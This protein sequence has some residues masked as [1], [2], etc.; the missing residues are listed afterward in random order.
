MITL[1]FIGIHTGNFK[2][3]F[4]LTKN[5]VPPKEINMIGIYKL[6]NKI[7]G[8]VYIGQS[9]NIK[10]RWRGHKFES[11]IE[12]NGW[13]FYN[14]IRKYGWE[15]FIR[16]ILIEITDD[17]WVEELL[18]FY[19]VYFVFYYESM[20][21]TGKGYNVKFPGSNG[22]MSED[23]K[24][25]MRLSQKGHFVSEKTRNKIRIAN[26]GKK[27]SQETIEKRRSKLIGKKRQ[28]NLNKNIEEVIMVIMVKKYILIVKKQNV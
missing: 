14:A 28:K 15:N 17:T 2:I 23:S 25:K 16:E 22:P 20:K 12:D 10:N 5:R 27:Q 18:N 11:K 9:R 24:K 8:K 4:Q 3:F 6:T 21:Y 1:Y 13:Y 26:S 7:N 19:E